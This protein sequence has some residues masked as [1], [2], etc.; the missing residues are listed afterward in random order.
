MKNLS[1]C[2]V[3]KNNSRGGGCDLRI[4]FF[5]NIQKEF[6]FGGGGGG[7]AGW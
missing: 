7:G 5:V 6:F 2:E 4:E 1:F 3:K